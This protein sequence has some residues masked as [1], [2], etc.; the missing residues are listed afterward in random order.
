M[1]LLG[2]IAGTGFSSLAG[3]AID[4]ASE[5]ETSYGLSS[6]PL[7]RGRLHGKPVVFLQRHGRDQGVAP[8]LI[9]YRANLQALS[10]AGVHELLTVNAVGGISK[11]CAPGT[12]LI[13]DDLIDYTWG[14][15]STFFDGR[16]KPLQHTEFCPPF[17][18]G[19]RQR[20]IAAAAEADEPVIARGVYGVVQGPR[21]E[22]AAEIRRMAHDGCD[23]VGM[24]AM[25]EAVLARE[26]AIPSASCAIVVNPAAG[27]ATGSIHEQIRE[28]LEVGTQRFLRV[29]EA[30]VRAN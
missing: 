29:L 14:R 12:L 18:E 7:A 20:L 22:T 24:T 27:L 9:N 25:P 30:F 28:S 15:D 19:I 4:Q 21:L 3:F 5:V 26:L 8:H 6:G 17:D 2:I 13:P 11:N 10:D 16:D 23:V 1:S